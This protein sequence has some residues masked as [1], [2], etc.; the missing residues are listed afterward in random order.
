VPPERG[1]IGMFTSLT[2]M[3]TLVDWQRLQQRAAKP[4]LMRTGLAE[5][6][7]SQLR[8]NS[9]LERTVPA[10]RADARRATAILHGGHSTGTLGASAQFNR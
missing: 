6:P 3:G 5:M 10:P 1:G 7:R 2:C 4:F 8:P 9:S